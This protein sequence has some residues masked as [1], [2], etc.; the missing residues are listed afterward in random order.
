[1]EKRYGIRDCSSWG[2]VTIRDP[3]RLKFIEAIS[4]DGFGF[5]LCRS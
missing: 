3:A 5:Y 4:V 1:M 2:T